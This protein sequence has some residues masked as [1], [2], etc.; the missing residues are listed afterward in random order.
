MS[1]VSINQNDFTMINEIGYY[2]EK[3]KFYKNKMHELNEFL[4]TIGP[5]K[6][7][8]YKDFVNGVRY[9]NNLK[10][11]KTHLE[12]Q[13]SIEIYIDTFFHL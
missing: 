5:S 10:R 1:T 12:I 11:R 7:K 6:P 13:Y 4:Y 2:D 8:N 3:F 9:A